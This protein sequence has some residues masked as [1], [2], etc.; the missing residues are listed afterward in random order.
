MASE[1]KNE[2]I[3]GQETEFEG[4]L[5]FSDSLVI[6]GKF[7]GN[8]NATG[9]LEIEKSAVCNVDKMTASTVVVSG[10]VNGNIEASKSVELCKG[11]KV[12]GDI[13][14]PELRIADN[15]EFEGSVNM[16]DEIPDTDIFSISSDEYKKSLVLKN[17]EFN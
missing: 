12:K 7:N 2:T 1:K 8:I 6:T 10:R 15:V 3:F 9:D 17:S 11:S 14:T 13:T 16:L 5:T 4:N